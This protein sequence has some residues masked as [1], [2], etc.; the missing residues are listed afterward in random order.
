M[1]EGSAS[2]NGVLRVAEWIPAAM[3]SHRGRRRRPAKG[4]GG[5]RAVVTAAIR[6][7]MCPCGVPEATCST[8]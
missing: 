1:A 2:H 3:R 8:V 5:R 6:S 4:L 7:K